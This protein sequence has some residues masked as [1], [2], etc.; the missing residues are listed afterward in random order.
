MLNRLPVAVE[1]IPG[2]AIVPRCLYMLR[3]LFRDRR[4]AEGATVEAHEIAEQ[5]HE[6]AEPHAHAA[7][8]RD[9]FRR[10]TAIYVGVVAMLLAISALGGAEATKEMLNAN[11]HA[12]DTYA[13]YQSKYI[14]QVL[15][16]T[17]AEELELTAATAANLVPEQRAK[18]D[19]VVKRYR[20]TA[21]RYESEPA[22]ADGKPGEG[23]KELMARAKQWERTRDHAAARLPN[24]EYAEALYQIAIVLGSVAI[25]AAS[26]W[27]LGVSGVLAACGLALTVNG[28]LLLVQLPHGDEAHAMPEAAAAAR[29]AA[30]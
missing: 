19:Q 9:W 16:Q 28:H 25:V 10:L 12:S 7:P 29:P 11:I 4:G 13:F 24:F 14:R 5:I 20:D 3:E 27:L 30:H 18:V 21:L 17:A 26:P 15:L 2:D 22:T 6:H 23:K 1:R 8:T